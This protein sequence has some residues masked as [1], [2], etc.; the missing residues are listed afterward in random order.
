MIAPDRACSAAGSPIRSQQIRRVRSMRSARSCR[1]SA[2]SSSCSGCLQADTNGLLMAAL[3]AAGVGFLLWFF[4]YTRGREQAGKEP[5]L[6]LRLF[7]NRTSNLGLVTQNIQWL[8]LMGVSFTVSVFLQ[9]V[10]GYN[11]IETGVIFTA[12]TLG[13]LALVARRRAPGQA[14]PAADV[15]HGRLRR[16]RGGHRS[17]SRAGRGLVARRRVRARPAPDRTRP[18]RHAHSLGRPRAIELPR[19]AAGR[20]LGSVAQR[21]QPRLVVWHCDRRHDP[22]LRPRVG[23]HDVRH[24]DGR[25]RG[26]RAHRPRRGHPAPTRAAPRGRR[27]RVSRAPSPRRNRTA[28]GRAGASSGTS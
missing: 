19:A 27:A 2:C 15:D 5:L 13:V 25:P 26:A 7:K 1:R 18:R 10:R 28:S 11:A 23:Q 16:H 6:S 4:L 9:T 14:A 17:S 12:A 20:D 8:L 24:R 3:M 22:G 21:L